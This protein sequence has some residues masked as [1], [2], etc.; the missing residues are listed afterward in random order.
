MARHSSDR[1][2][3]QHLRLRFP[4]ALLALLSQLSACAI[5][6]DR[7]EDPPAP[8]PADLEAAASVLP[9]TQRVEPPAGRWETLAAVVRARSGHT[10]VLTE[11]NAS[12][13]DQLLT[14]DPDHGALVALDAQ[15]L[16]VLHTW[17]V[18]QDP[19]HVATADGIAWVSLRG[20]N[21]VARVDLQTDAIT[22]L[23]TERAPT[24][25]AILPG[26]DLLVA[27]SGPD[28]LLRLDGTT[29]ELRQERTTPGGTPRTVALSANGMVMTTAPQG[30]L[31]SGHVQTALTNW[32]YQRALET[33]GMVTSCNSTLAT[34][35]L[36]P[37]HAFSIATDVQNFYI[38]HHV[39]NSGKEKDSL[40]ANAEVDPEACVAQ[41][42]LPQYYGGHVAAG[43]LT[44][45]RRP[46]ELATTKID[47]DSQA[48]AP[49]WPASNGF[50]NPTMR[51][52]KA[53]AG[54]IDQPVDIVLHP[55][56][57]MAAIAGRGSDNVLLISTATSQVLGTAELPLG[58]APAG[59][60][61][62][63]D[64]KRLFA[65]A[66]NRFRV[67]EFTLP[68]LSA[69]FAPLA[70]QP[71]HESAQFAADPLTERQQ[72]GRQLFFQSRNPA[73]SAEARFSC[74]S[75]H[76]NGDNDGLVWFIAD[77]A[78]QTPNLAG[79]LQG[80]GPFN[81]KGSQSLLANNMADTV[82]RMGGGGLSTAD[83][84]ALEDF[85][86]NALPAPVNPN[87][88]PDGLT[89]QQLRGQALF[90]NPTVGCA[91][92]HTPGVGTDGLSHDVSTANELDKSIAK[93]RGDPKSAG[94]F[95]TPSL[96]GL[97]KSAPYLHDGSAPTLYSLLAL[98]SDLKLMGDTS[99]LSSA[100]R[101]DLIAYLLT[102]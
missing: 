39:V 7:F 43:C 29:G 47:I 44:G 42:P 2:E 36:S 45:P 16:Q 84:E 31:V 65:L 62:S 85:V 51:G 46:I 35:S 26:G 30:D 9:D 99:A 41:A 91:G 52:G 54:E 90:T 64:G 102:L 59:L 61:W 4:V 70:L 72:R 76:V 66:R 68:N 37:G 73:I 8:C 80:T 55:T 58:S 98:T 22:F 10:L 25:L 40:A 53:L 19:Y 78:R 5:Q 21:A 67:T 101:A 13:A 32:D 27:V 89:D 3:H 28:R 92:C 34:A 6:R 69:P 88:A 15:T 74:A 86:V 17:P 48:S 95:N 63:R 23:K 87:L 100:Q 20:G 94:L 49:A 38:A 33:D 11:P 71:S 79:R 77:G 93:M 12:G 50:I 83:M 97:Y 14:V 96:H 56:L 1:H 24:G 60:A 82:H 18:G 75:C 57:E 81:W